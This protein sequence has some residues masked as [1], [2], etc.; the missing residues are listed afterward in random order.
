MSHASDTRHSFLCS[1]GGSGA[2]KA[3]DH[4]QE[5]R[6]AQARTMS[7][8]QLG[9]PAGHSRSIGNRLS[10]EKYR[11]LRGPFVANTDWPHHERGGRYNQNPPVDRAARCDEWVAP[12]RVCPASLPPAGG[13]HERPKGKRRIGENTNVLSHTDTL[14]WGIDVD[15]SDGVLNQAGSVLYK[16]S[17][18]VNERAERTP[19]YGHLPPTCLRTF[20][21]EG[22]SQDFE[23]GGSFQRRDP[24]VDY[25]EGG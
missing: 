4:V 14:I 1:H 19:I 3:H 18:G 22:S 10:L 13:M 6:F 2:R 12:M 5:S 24:R 8:P 16:G 23:G 15:G 20:G 9:V 11:S 21:P 25:V 7:L 17:A